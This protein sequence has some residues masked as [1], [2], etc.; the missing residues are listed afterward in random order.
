MITA[1]QLFCHALGDYFFQSDWMAREKTKRWMPAL[2]HA[3]VYGLAFLMLNPS[4]PALAVIVLSHALIDRLRLARYPV[5]AKNLLAPRMDWAEWKDCAATGY[6]DNKPA[7][8]AVWLLIIADNLMHVAINA[9][10]LRWM[11]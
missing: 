7:W 10:A 2:I 9:A 11:P 6:P 3:G 8:M 1:D 5:W 4:P